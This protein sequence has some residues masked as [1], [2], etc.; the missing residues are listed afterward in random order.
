MSSIVTQLESLLKSV[1]LSRQDVLE[2]TECVIQEYLNQQEK[3]MGVHSEDDDEEQLIDV[4]LD[5]DGDYV[6]E[7]GYIYDEKTHIRI[8]Q[9]D[10]KTKEKTMFNVV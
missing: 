1:T 9:K 2:L 10:L 6:D 4:H 8:G 5:E 7:E 3:E